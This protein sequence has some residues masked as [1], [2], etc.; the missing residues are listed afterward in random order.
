[1]SQIAHTHFVIND[2]LRYVANHRAD[3]ELL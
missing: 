3:M 2:T 1:L